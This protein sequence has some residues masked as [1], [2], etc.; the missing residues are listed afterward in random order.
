M[1]R[2]RLFVRRHLGGRNIGA[3]AER[4]EF[5]H[6]ECVYCFSNVVGSRK[7]IDNWAIL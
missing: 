2:G 3:L 5:W 7:C 6:R 1:Q 4:E